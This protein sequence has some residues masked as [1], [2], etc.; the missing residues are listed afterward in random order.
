MQ[1][2]VTLIGRLTTKACEHSVGKH[3]GVNNKAFLSKDDDDD[4]TC[5]YHSFGTN[6]L[7]FINL[8]K[9]RFLGVH[10]LLFGF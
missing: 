2:S 8:L 4:I 6:K 10:H 1:L 7:N 3:S 9:I 5:T